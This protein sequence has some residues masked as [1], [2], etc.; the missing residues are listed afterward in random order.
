MSLNYLGHPRFANSHA[1][2][3][4]RRRKNTSISSSRYWSRSIILGPLYNLVVDSFIAIS[5]SYSPKR[6][7]CRKRKRK[8]M[9]DS[10]K[11]MDQQ[12]SSNSHLQSISLGNASLTKELGWNDCTFQ[13]PI[14]SQSI[15][16]RSRPSLSR[17]PC[18][19]P[20]LTLQL[21]FLRTNF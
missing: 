6:L 7:A 2:V 10:F 1:C 4:F 8:A 14:R 21:T 5:R 12:Y 15:F 9:D 16:K 20:S 3:P 19:I 11:K 13:S 18:T 17:T